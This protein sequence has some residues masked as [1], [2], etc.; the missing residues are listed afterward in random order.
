MQACRRLVA[1]MREQDV[2]RHIGAGIEI[3]D[4]AMVPVLGDSRDPAIHDRYVA[5]RQI[6]PDI[7]RKVVAIGKERQSV[8]PVVEQPGLVVGLRARPD[9]APMLACD[10]KTIAIGA[11]HDG[12]AP[13]FGKARDVGHLVGDAITQDQAPRRKAFTIGSEDGEIVNGAGHAFGPGIDQLDRGIAH[14]LLAR[15]G[16]DVEWWL[17]IVAE[18]AMRMAGEAVARQAGIENGDLAAGAAKLQRGGETGKAAA[19][20]SD[21][22]HDNGLRVVVDGGDRTGLARNIAQRETLETGDKLGENV[23]HAA[24]NRE[25]A[26]TTSAQPGA[27]E[28][29]HPPPRARKEAM[30]ARAA[31]A[32]D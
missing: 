19:D 13:A 22:I 1:R 11:R 23:A 30:A 6:G 5:E 21:V 7:W 12:L 27:I 8:G 29:S 20:D 26:P 16:E 32:F 2:D 18:H 24:A 4:G 31:A 17:V 15:L 25:A 14:Q 28:A 9:E 3:D 10:F